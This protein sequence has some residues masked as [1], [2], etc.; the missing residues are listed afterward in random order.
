M[1]VHLSIHDNRIIPR[2]HLAGVAAGCSVSVFRIEPAT[3]ELHEMLGTAM[4]GEGGWVDM[5]EPTTVPAG[6]A[7]IAPAEADSNGPKP[8]Q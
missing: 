8:V 1:V 4:V 7:F 2:F 5:A 3:G 6:E